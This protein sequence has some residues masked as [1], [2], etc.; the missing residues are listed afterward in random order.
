MNHS[1]YRDIC[2][3]KEHKDLPVTLRNTRTGETGTLIQCSL[4]DTPEALLVSIH[5]EGFTTWYPPEVQE[6]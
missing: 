5:G 1:E 2:A 6:L 4:W 3:R